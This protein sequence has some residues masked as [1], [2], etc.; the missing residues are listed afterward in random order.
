MKNGRGYALLLAGLMLIGVSQNL[1]AQVVAGSCGSHTLSHFSSIQAAVNAASA[2]GTVLVCPGTYPEQVLINKALTVKG[3]NDDGRDCDDDHPQA[4]ITSPAGGMVANSTDGNGFPVAA[5]IAVQAQHVNIQEVTADAINNGF[6]AAACSTM[7]LAGI[8]YLSSSGTVNEVE[9]RNVTQAVPGCRT[10]SG[11]RVENP[12]GSSSDVTIKSS[13]IHDYSAFGV[14]DVGT[15]AHANIFGN[16]IAG[17]GVSSPIS[18]AG[19]ELVSGATGTVIGNRVSKN[20]VTDASLASTGIL[21]VGS[22]GAMIGG[23]DVSA[24][25]FGISL[26]NIPG[27]DSNNGV[28]AFN[29]VSA[30]GRDGIWLC[31]NNNLVQANLVNQSGQSGI[32]LVGVCLSEAGGS[33]NS[34]QANFINGACAGVLESPSTTGNTLTGNI[35]KNVTNQVLIGTSCP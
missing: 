31:S 23:N 28:I 11:I 15:G 4:I 9:V 8:A 29:K 32:N 27:F 21:G 12:P 18:Q 33:N 1:T 10:G 7:R 17:L 34:I 2:G 26:Q 30:T 24:N 5:L 6:N 19:V 22:H 14:I 20:L 35:F 3:V 16:T 25:A 13:S